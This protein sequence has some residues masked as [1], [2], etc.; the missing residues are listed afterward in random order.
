MLKILWFIIQLLNWSLPSNSNNLS[1]ISYLTKNTFYTENV[2]FLIKQI[3][4]NSLKIIKQEHKR[5][6]NCK[7][8]ERSTQ[9]SCKDISKML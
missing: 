4:S 8:Y 6:N 9:S 3:L 1:L 5:T 7:K 2:Y